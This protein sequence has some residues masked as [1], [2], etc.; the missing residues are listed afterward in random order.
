MMS[1]I[2]AARSDDGI[3][4]DFPAG[5]DFLPLLGGLPCLDLA[6]PRDPRALRTFGTAGRNPEISSDLERIAAVDLEPEALLTNAVLREDAALVV[7]VAK[8]R[9]P[10]VVRLFLH[11]RHFLA[12]LGEAQF[13]MRGLDVTGRAADATGLRSN[14]S[15][16]RRVAKP[17]SAL[18]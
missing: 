9:R 18:A 4:L 11:S 16:V 12:G 10:A 14:E 6:R 3:G 5:L 15:K 17:G 13:Q 8:R 2:K 7:I 1:P